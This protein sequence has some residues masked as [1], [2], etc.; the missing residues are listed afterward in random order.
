MILK[1][2]GLFFQKSTRYIAWSR[3]SFFQTKFLCGPGLNQAYLIFLTFGGQFFIEL[4][5]I[6][7]VKILFFDYRP[8]CQVEATPNAPKNIF[9]S[10]LLAA[11]VNG[12]VTVYI[13]GSK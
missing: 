12:A 5:V 4:C 11:A 13:L 7:S 2:V 8:L 1:L 6:T 9:F 10:L 3:S